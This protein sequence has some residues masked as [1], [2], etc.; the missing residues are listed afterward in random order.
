MKLTYA[1]SGMILVVGSGF[2]EVRVLFRTPFEPSG[3]VAVGAVGDDVVS[4]PGQEVAQERER[5]R[6]LASRWDHEQGQHVP[7]PV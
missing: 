7:P 6:V 1:C 5:L 3:F 4:D 2:D